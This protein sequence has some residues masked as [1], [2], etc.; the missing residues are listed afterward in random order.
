MSWLPR[1]DT[2]EQAVVLLTKLHLVVELTA[3]SQIMVDSALATLKSATCD[4]AAQ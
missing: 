2:L 1:R 4:Q 3:L